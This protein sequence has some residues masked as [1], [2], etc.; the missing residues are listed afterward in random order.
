MKHLEPDQR[1]APASGIA[2]QA[3]APWHGADFMLAMGEATI[4]G[5]SDMDGELRQDI[6]LI[7]GYLRIGID[8]AVMTPSAAVLL[9]SLRTDCPMVRWTLC[10]AG[11]S[12][13]YD[14]LRTAH[15]DLAIWRGAPIEPH[16]LL[17]GHMCQQLFCRE[18]LSIAL[19]RD[20]RMARRNSISLGDLGDRGMLASPDACVALSPLLLLALVGS[21]AGAA[22]VPRSMA[23]MAFPNVTVRRLHDAPYTNVYLAYSLDSKSSGLRPFFDILNKERAARPF[24][25]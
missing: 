2:P 6:D 12:H 19:P 20:H 10:D 16:K 3:A 17:Q 5:A 9:R 11:R 24:F 8:S 4:G 18:E 21:G 7:Q 23:R 1:L 13:Q 15:V 22:L 14:A 25:L